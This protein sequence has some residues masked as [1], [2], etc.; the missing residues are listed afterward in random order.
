V[1]DAGTARKLKAWYRQLDDAAIPAGPITDIFPAQH[2]LVLVAPGGMG[3]TTMVGHLCRAA[4]ARRQAAE[5][6]GPVP[7]VVLIR[8]FLPAHEESGLEPLIIRTLRS[9][10]NCELTA[11][12]LRAA[13]ESGLVFL[14][15]DGLDEVIGQLVATGGDG[16]VRLWDLWL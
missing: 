1:R 8:D 13:L 2:R 11:E 12:A 4:A 7:L 10:Y 3:K 6:T 14:V 9:R 16:T 5:N 15:A